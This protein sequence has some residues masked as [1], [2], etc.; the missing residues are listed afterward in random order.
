VT[1]RGWLAVGIL[2]WLGGCD[3]DLPP[4][5]PVRLP[6]GWVQGA[7]DPLRWAVAQVQAQLHDRPQD[8]AGRPAQGARAVLLVEYLS[9]A[10]MAGNVADAWQLTRVWRG[11][12]G[13]LRGNLGLRTDVPPVAMAAALEQAAAALD[14]GDAAAAPPC[15]APA[16]RPH[17]GGAARPGQAPSPAGRIV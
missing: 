11:A 12:R 7:T 17:G 1:R 3:G 16:P 9:T 13:A 15:A 10:F 14:R 6:Q 8:L 2:S 5:D 4:E